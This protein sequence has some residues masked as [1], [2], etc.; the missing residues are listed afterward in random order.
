MSD[1]KE[2]YVS[3]V[4]SFPPQ[5]PDTK[6]EPQDVNDLSRKVNKQLLDFSALLDSLTSLEEKKKALWKQIY[7]NAVTDRK[8]AYILFGD[9]YKDVHNEPAQHAI[10]GVTLTKYMERMEKSNNQLIKLAEM[11][12]EVVQ[13]DEEWVT[14]EDTMYDQIN[15]GKG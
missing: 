11:I 1:K 2:Q 12:E 14:D 15:K 7:E 8:N 13:T 3:P 10:H 6:F 4:Q 9:L 5:I